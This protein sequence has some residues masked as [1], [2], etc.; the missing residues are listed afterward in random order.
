M[1]QRIQLA[2]CAA[3]A[4]LS[5]SAHAGSG[6]M[7]TEVPRITNGGTGVHTL[8]AADAM[9]RQA[10]RAAHEGATTVPA[11]AGEASTMVQGRP[12]AQPAVAGGMHQTQ[13]TQAMGNARWSLGA[14]PAPA[15]HPAWGTPD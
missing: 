10:W 14:G 7:A 5:L 1:K 6:V 12:N 15:R 4:V 9:Q 8:P 3:A 13:G 2:L 11:Q